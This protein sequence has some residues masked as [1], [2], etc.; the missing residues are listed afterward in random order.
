M[1]NP[2]FFSY[3]HPIF[4]EE[5][6]KIPSSILVI[7]LNIAQDILHI[8]VTGR[9]KENLLITI[10]IILEWLIRIAVCELGAKLDTFRHFCY[11]FVTSTDLDS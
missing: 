5:E 4:T 1:T 9:K 11:D 6:M 2:L 8:T 3:F 10:I 7:Q